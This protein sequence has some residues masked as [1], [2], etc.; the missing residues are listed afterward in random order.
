MKMNEAVIID[1]LMERIRKCNNKYWI[2]KL[3]NKDNFRIHVAVMTEPYLHYVL[4]GKKVLEARFSKNRGIPW[5]KVSTGDAVILKKSGGNFTGI[6]EVNSVEYL[7]IKE[8]YTIAFIR[9]QY[10]N[11]LCIE[12]EFWKI[13]KDSRYVSLFGI[14]QVC[15]F[16]PFKISGVNRRSWILLNQ[17]A[18][19][20]R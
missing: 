2:E 1:K 10:N 12:E 6:F 7:E 18:R 5:N 11:E 17:N 13:K 19:F 8:N 20:T 15:S 16:E 9:S 3:K 14:R 4:S